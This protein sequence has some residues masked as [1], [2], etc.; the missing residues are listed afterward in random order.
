MRVYEPAGLP[1]GA[2]FF[3]GTLFRLPLRTQTQAKESEIRNQPFT[4]ENVQELLEELVQVGE[5]LLLFLKSVVEI[6]VREIQ[7]DGTH[8]E[9]ISIVTTNQ[10]EVTAQRQILRSPL[11]GNLEV[12]IAQAKS[13]PAVSY[14]H[15]IETTTETEIAQSSWRVSS[16]MRVDEQ[17]QLID[18]LQQLAQQNQKAIPWAGAAACIARTSTTSVE[19]PFQGRA[20]CFLPLPQ[21]TGLPVHINGFFDLD[22]SRRELTRDNLTGRD[23]IRVTWNQLLV[24]HVLAHAYANLVTELVGDLGEVDPER[25]YQFLPTT[26]TTGILT[27]L[28]SG[29][30]KLLNSRQIVRSTVSRPTVTQWDGKREIHESHWIKPSEIK[31]LPQDWEDLINPLRLEKV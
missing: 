11:Q 26:A 14:R 3:N 7:C 25:F 2:D 22:S 12:F 10:D 6:R 18:V 4:Q 23:K 13:L 27:D 16:L 17:G 15:E 9:L 31:V 24:R 8:R 1:T 28:S 21:M 29:V 19:Q 30:F 5:D 20:Y